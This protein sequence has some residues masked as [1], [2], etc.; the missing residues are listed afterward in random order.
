[1][2]DVP[3]RGPYARTDA[4]GVPTRGPYARVIRAAAWRQLDRAT[5]IAM[6]IGLALLLQ[7]W[8]SGG[9]RIG[10]FVTLTA[11][12]AQIGASHAASATTESAAASGDECS[13]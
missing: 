2:T 3:S 12:V 4:A 13:R 5:L 1:M 6:A 8:W 9:F 7:P 10:F 11:T